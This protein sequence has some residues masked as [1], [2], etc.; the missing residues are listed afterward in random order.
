MAV[1]KI[2]KTKTALVAEGGG[3]RGIFCA[4]VLDVFFENKFDPFDLY[5]GVSA[6]ACN[7]ASHLSGQHRRNY[8]I[9]MDLMTGPEFISLKKFMRGGH[10]MDLD[11]LWDTIDVRIPLAVK[12]IFKK[13]KKE[14]II[15]G[16][17]ALSGEPVYIQ[18]TPENCSLALKAS[19][20]V[21]LLYR[22]F[23][24]ISGIDMVDGGVADPIPVI[25]AFRRGARNIVIIRTRPPEYYK[26][27]GLENI[28]SSLAMR[29]FPNLSKAVAGQAD[30]Y[31]KC[32]DFILNPPRDTFITQ[33]A[34][35]Q[36]LRTGRT[37]QD[38]ECLVADYELG[39]RHG[40]AFISAWE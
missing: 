32:M 6:G 21:P 7:L 31:R 15:T 13:K 5:I 39:R 26:T 12:D 28:V 23:I 38:R 9:Y 14:F 25:E 30:T 37:T 22:H 19:S 18:P 35:V 27:K 3:M 20:A 29:K 4:G 33:I 1:I 17:N 24:D 2:V 40:E 16:T 11:Y 34:P 10:L 36:P 8:N